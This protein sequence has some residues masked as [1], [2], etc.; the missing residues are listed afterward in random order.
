M[1]TIKIKLSQG[2]IK[3]AREQLQETKQDVHD[4]MREFVY[5]LAKYGVEV[6]ES[7]TGVWG[8]Y[9][10]FK[11]DTEETKT[12][13]KAIVIMYDKQKI[14]PKH[15]DR[16]VSPSLMAEYGAG[17]FAVKGWQGTFPDQIHAFNPMGWWYLGND[18]KWHHSYGVVPEKPMYTAYQE[19]LKTINDVAKRVFA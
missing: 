15:D 18:D 4:K 7:N 3:Q 13:C 17:H 1:P 8:K 16:E 2:G 12:G 5:E 19:V 14:K 11:I 6:A 9:I 10:Q